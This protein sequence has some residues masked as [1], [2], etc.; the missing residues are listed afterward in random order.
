MSVA[1]RF[2]C[3]CF[4]ISPIYYLQTK[5]S[6]VLG[7]QKVHTTPFQY[8][9]GRQRYKLVRGLGLKGSKHFLN[10]WIETNLTNLAFNRELRLILYYAHT[11]YRSTHYALPES[12]GLRRMPLEVY[13]NLSGSDALQKTKNQNR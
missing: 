2:R 13:K 1:F 7:K 4:E 6:Q 11:L 3:S 12:P 9:N 5:A 8:Q 10:L